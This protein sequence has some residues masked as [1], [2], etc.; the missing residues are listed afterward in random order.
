MEASW[1]RDSSQAKDEKLYKLTKEELAGLGRLGEWTQERL[2]ALALTK[3]DEQFALSAKRPAT[4]VQ[5]RGDRE[6]T[7]EETM[8]AFFA[9][10][11]KRNISE[12]HSWL[13]QSEAFDGKTKEYILDFLYELSGQLATGATTILP[14]MAPSTDRCALMLVKAQ[15][16]R[17]GAGAPKTLPAYDEFLPM[18]K[19][20]GEWR[21]IHDASLNAT[22]SRAYGL[23]REDSAA[24]AKLRRQMH[25]EIDKLCLQDLAPISMQ[26]LK[27]GAEL[28]PFLEATPEECF[29]DLVNA[30]RKNDFPR[31][32]LW[33]AEADCI[34]HYDRMNFLSE[35]HKFAAG[36]P[37]N[38][39][40]GKEILAHRD[41]NVALLVVSMESL[42]QGVL[43]WKTAEGWRILPH[44][45]YRDPSLARHRLSGEFIQSY[46]FNKKDLAS[47]Q[48]VG[49]WL[50]DALEPKKEDVKP[51]EENPPAASEGKKSGAE[52]K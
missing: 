18:I 17:A 22:T 6:T 19:Q 42:V 23:T 16:K 43:I 26:A 14:V 34:T 25:R 8:R 45:D 29:L 44:P 7:A 40:A 24:Y 39:R 4:R 52:G 30:G 20:E 15:P 33:L 9:A 5:L 35:F 37:P 32:L 21:I 27:R 48:A 13:A 10:L 2:A 49:K 31:M 12:A 51:G 46:G 36:V 1:Q 41:G 38:V 47:F 28:A 3:I 11:K 50:D